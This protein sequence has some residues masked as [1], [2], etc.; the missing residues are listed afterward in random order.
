MENMEMAKK[1]R[2]CSR[3]MSTNE[4]HMR[5]CRVVAQ[6]SEYRPHFEYANFVVSD[7]VIRHLMGLLHVR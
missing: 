5:F 6:R 1:D 3:E 4:R 7:Y 2:K